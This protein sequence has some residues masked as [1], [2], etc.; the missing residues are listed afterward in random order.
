MDPARGSDAANAESQSPGATRPGTRGRPV[1]R[2]SGR[3]ALR[4]TKE[5]R[6]RLQRE[7]QNRRRQFENDSRQRT[8]APYNRGDRARGGQRGHG[9]GG[10]S[11]DAVSGAFSG[12]VATNISSRA[13]SYRGVASRSASAAVTE[14]R[15]SRVKS[16]RIEHDEDRDVQMLFGGEDEEEGEDEKGRVNID[17]IVL[18]SS[19]DDEE[20]GGDPS[21]SGAKAGKSRSSHGMT[22]I[23]I[24]RSEHVDP[25]IGIKSEA[26]TAAL[27]GLE[28]AKDSNTEATAKETS[29]EAV[30]AGKSAASD[31]E[32]IGIERAWKGAYTDDDEDR[33]VH[34]KDEPTDEDTL[35]VPAA[36]SDDQAGPSTQAL[37]PPESPKQAKPKPQSR[38]R[39]HDA[40][41]EFD[42]MYEEREHYLLEEKKRELFH[43]LVPDLHPSAAS[44]VDLK[45]DATK[46]LTDKLPSGKKDRIYLMQFPAILPQL[47]PAAQFVKR[48][49]DDQE[50][51]EDTNPT[52]PTNTEDVPMKIEEVETSGGAKAGGYVDPNHPQEIF[53]QAAADYEA[54]QLED[55]LDN[56]RLATAGRMGQLRIHKSGKTIIEWGDGLEFEISMGAV[57]SCIQDILVSKQVETE[58][59][60][61]RGMEA[62]AYGQVT[63][64]F[65]AHASRRMVERKMKRYDDEWEAGE[66]EEDEDEEGEHQNKEGEAVQVEGE[67]EAMVQ[68]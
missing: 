23:R 66:S 25:I 61:V 31:V 12:G 51:A 5:E 46:A 55:S 43:E 4:R 10:F 34:I 13:R 7:E 49:N 60:S 68:A 2:P 26:S 35:S 53:R 15:Q 47:I 39:P 16:E 32:F 33:P 19:D 67:G 36:P 37:L 44:Q 22:P 59:E 64:S 57:Q 21:G 48:E 45:K 56:P 54:A 20:L 65:V 38:S 27:P 28:K 41:H 9:R 58:R 6:E 52:N 62:V 63:G 24:R 29:T 14:S 18:I 17:E 8:A 11:M 1:A 3:G 42:D 30:R 40:A 50:N